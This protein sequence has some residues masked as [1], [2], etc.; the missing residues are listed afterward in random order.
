M[1]GFLMVLTALAGGIVFVANRSSVPKKDR[2]GRLKELT[3]L[4]EGHMEGIPGERAC[5][6]VKF[7]F[8]GYA[9]VFEDLVEQGM[10]DLLNRA[11]LKVSTKAR[12]SLDFTEKER[13]LR[14]T[15]DVVIVSEIKDVPLVPKIKVTPPPELGNLE[16]FTDDPAMVNEF[17][18]QRKVVKIFKAFQNKDNRGFVFNALRIKDGVVILEFYANSTFQPNLDVFWHNIY[19]IEDYADRL[20]FIARVMDRLVQE[21]TKDEKF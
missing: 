14:I 15:A 19:S 8:E 12:F 11:C 1:W 7:D 10:E 4:V 18:K 9:F 6:R 3:Q 21:R 5:Y 13:T 20:L 2:K 16:I 17:F